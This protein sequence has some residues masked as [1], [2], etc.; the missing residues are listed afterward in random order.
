M[1]FAQSF[2]YK[3]ALRLL[4]SRSIRD[5]HAR[6]DDSLNFFFVISYV[7][8]TLQISTESRF[9][10][11]LYFVCALFDIC[12]VPDG[13]E[14]FSYFCPDEKYNVVGDFDTASNHGPSFDD[15]EP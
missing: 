5:S 4:F 1:L 14:K 3:N 9:V 15:Y 12:T 10:Y 8:W 7:P 11:S 6:E 13:G 2:I